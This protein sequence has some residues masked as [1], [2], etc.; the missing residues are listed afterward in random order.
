MLHTK[1]KIKAFSVSSVKKIW[2]FGKR[3][4]FWVGKRG[5]VR[6]EGRWEAPKAC[7]GKGIKNVF[8]YCTKQFKIKALFFGKDNV[9]IFVIFF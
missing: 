2:V 1:R 3:F 5:P 4:C 7:F 9:F 8:L 6:H